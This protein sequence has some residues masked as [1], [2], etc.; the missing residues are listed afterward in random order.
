MVMQQVHGGLRGLIAGA[1]GLNLESLKC[2][3]V[4]TAYVKCLQTYT[5]ASL[6]IVLH[7]YYNLL[8]E[9]YMH[10]SYW[11]M[12]EL[13]KC[14][15][16]EAFLEFQISNGMSESGRGFEWVLIYADNALYIGHIKAPYL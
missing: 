13:L 16:E 3:H 5:H 2:T 14:M 8:S 12:S 7:I 15:N 11:C 1:L 10:V 4:C 9:N 6:Q